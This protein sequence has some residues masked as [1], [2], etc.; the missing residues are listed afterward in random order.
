MR[1]LVVA[2]SLVLFGGVTYEVSQAER[3]I[4]QQSTKIRELEAKLRTATATIRPHNGSLKDQ[5]LCAQQAERAFRSAQDSSDPRG[6]DYFVS[7]YEPASTQC[8]VEIDRWSISKG[9]SIVTRSISNAISGEPL[10][11]YGWANKGKKYWEVK[12]TMCEVIDRNGHTKYCESD[13]EF[14]ELARQYMK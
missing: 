9:T 13:D 1:T 4:E 6:L 5:I 3:R 12:P 10:G 7:H 11:T 8:F 14:T 2:I